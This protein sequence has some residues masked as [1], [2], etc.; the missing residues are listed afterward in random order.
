MTAAGAAAQS[1]ADKIVG[2][3]R[4]VSGSD[5]SRVKISK[6]AGGYRAQIVWLEHPKNS[7][8]SPRTDK[9]N[10]DP[11]K[12]SVHSD[13]IVLVDKAV[14]RDGKWTDCK[15]YDPTKGKTFDCKMWFKDEKTLV[16]QGS[17][18]VF[19]KKMYWT[20]LASKQVDK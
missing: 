11:A 10:P 2:T 13:R 18:L 1:A 17:L 8:G 15:I 6:V 7:D 20:R 14:Y 19:T 16:V 4:A 3:Y 12:R 9:K 5:V